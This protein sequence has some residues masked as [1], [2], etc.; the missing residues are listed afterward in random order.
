MLRAWLQKWEAR[1]LNRDAVTII[2]ADTH[3]H[4]EPQLAAIAAQ[5]DV[6]RELARQRVTNEQ[7]TLEMLKNMHRRARD[8]RDQIKLSAATLAIIDFRARELGEA[9]QPAV[10]AIDR[11]MAQHSPAVDGDRSS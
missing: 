1:R 8:E 10:V 7:R 3:S 2:E 11:F 9:A 4:P 5:I 6:I